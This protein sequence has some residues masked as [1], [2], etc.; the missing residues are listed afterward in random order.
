MARIRGKNTGPERLMAEMLCSFD[1]SFE[2]HCGDL[3][4]RPDFVFR[5]IKLVIFV[6]GDFWHG[7][8]FPL[9]RHKLTGKWEQKIE[10]TRKR[11]RRN[12]SR[13]RR[14]GWRVVRF[15]E[16][17]VVSEPDKCRSRLAGLFSV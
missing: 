9:W 17:H 10:E 3:P 8:R 6:D 16:H 7:W 14:S 15:W 5:D 1:L 12:H 2:S 13:L 4:G 11:D